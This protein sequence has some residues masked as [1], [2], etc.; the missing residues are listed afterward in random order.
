VFADLKEEEFEKITLESYW[1][2]DSWKNYCKYISER[3]LESKRPSE[4]LLTYKEWNGI[5]IDEDV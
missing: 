5:G 1:S 4:Y 3:G 2:V